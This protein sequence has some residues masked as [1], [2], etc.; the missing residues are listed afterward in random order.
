MGNNSHHNSHHNSR[1]PQASPKLPPSID[2]DYFSGQMFNEYTGNRKT[3]INKKKKKKNR[4]SP[5][6]SP[7][8]IIRAK[9][10]LK[11]FHLSLCHSLTNVLLVMKWND[12][13]TP[14]ST[15]SIHSCA[16]STDLRQ[17]F[18]EHKDIK[19]PSKARTPV[20][21]LTELTNMEVLKGC[22]VTC[23]CVVTASWEAEWECDQWTGDKIFC[24]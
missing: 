24:T 19:W 21:S 2:V 4:R 12:T 13:C 23:M 3:S 6:R 8:L 5:T 16:E 17:S 9:T 10:T 15:R 14:P 22:N 18:G 1:R 7:R 11:F 20:R